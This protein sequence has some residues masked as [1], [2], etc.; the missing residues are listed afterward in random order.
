MDNRKK[1]QYD[2][3]SLFSVI[4]PL[5]LVL[6]VMVFGGY[7]AT[8][9]VREFYYQ[10]KLQEA[11]LLARDYAFSL[12]IVVD[13]K[14][15]LDNQMYST[16]KVAGAMVA[17]HKE[18]FSRDILSDMAENLDVD[19]IYVYDQDTTI[20]QSSDGKY[21]GWKAPEGHPVL[22]F[23]E[24]KL[25][26]FIEDIRADSESGELY[27]YGYY[28]FADNRMVQVGLKA[29]TIFSLYAQ[30]DAQYMIDT[31]TK[32]TPYINLVYLDM[33]NRVVASSDKDNLSVNIDASRLKLPLQPNTS[34]RFTWEGKD[35]L[36]LRIPITIKGRT[37]GSLLLFYDLQQEENLIFRLSMIIG[38]TLLAFFLLF[39]I[40][41]LKIYRKNSRMRSIAFHDE[42]TGL[43]N[44]RSFFQELSDLRAENLACIAFNPMNFRLLNI[45]YGYDHGD[46]VLKT[47]GTAL[48]DLQTRFP[49]LQVFK[50]SDDRFLLLLS[51][52]VSESYLES[53]LHALL[54]LKHENRMFA[55]LT[56]SL[57]VVESREGRY[58]ASLM[59]KQASIA[60]N[61]CTVSD[62]I[63]F[64]NT[65]LE[66]KLLRIDTIEQDLKHALSEE[67]ETL[68]LVY[69][70]IFT[71]EE[72]Q[73]VS[74][75]ALARME[76][77][78]L[79]PISPLE[80]I[81]IAEQRQLIIPLG[82]RLLSLACD[83][84]SELQ[85]KGNKPIKIAVNISA[86]QLL[87]PSFIPSLKTILAAKHVDPHGLELELTESVFAQNLQ[88]VAEQLKDIRRIGIH[89]A[90]DDF[91]TGYSSLSRIEAL[92]I[93]EV[94]L[95]KSFIDKLDNPATEGLIGDII[96]MAHHIEKPVVAE[97]VETKRQQTLLI[98]LGCDL[99][100]GY[101]MGKPMASSEALNLFLGKEAFHASIE[102]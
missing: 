24:S 63:Q 84:L 49:K 71:I 73:L 94:K 48:S 10:Q 56:F 21:I 100:Q 102:S 58:D 31:I 98:A 101:L 51:D 8:V 55:S 97:G 60:L 5:V 47:I 37:A 62:P 20:T 82:R 30:F 50:F 6:F 90:I 69:Q 40:S 39:T 46:E 88:N 93:D 81:D 68:W 78:T 36:V 59:V 38:A 26:Y 2:K 92:E 52:Y 45:I 34:S 95:D 35:Y 77:K 86:I 64:Y 65:T 70:P 18:P 91:G 67:A 14:T 19:V 80:F 87:D 66:E 43:T 99:L 96:S 25:Q 33:V 32:E 12:S 23:H 75:E 61:A 76:S 89:I 22:A 53:L 85:H 54:S 41:L 9:S 16:L 28:R 72:G 7:W 74:F 79:G 15:E 11:S 83:F 42:L 1:R 3:H 17:Q 57:G 29:S 27:K 44:L 13:A 4:L